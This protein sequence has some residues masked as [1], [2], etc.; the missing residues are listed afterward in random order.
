M[1]MVYT[2][3]PDEAVAMDVCKKLV[4]E[5]LAACCNIFNIKSVYTWDGN[6]ESGNEVGVIIKTRKS[7]FDRLKARLT[8]LHPYRVPPVIMVEV[9]RV[10]EAY[11]QWLNEVTVEE[12]R[13]D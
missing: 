7:L 3:F 10:N 9:S 12:K 8:E 11:L 6:L 1:A 4:S 5:R 13:K 2:T